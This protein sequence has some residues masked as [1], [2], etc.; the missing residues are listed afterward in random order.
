[1]AIYKEGIAINYVLINILYNTSEK[2]EESYNI[3]L[4]DINKVSNKVFNRNI[5]L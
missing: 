4:D 5:C 1:M 3:K 2:I